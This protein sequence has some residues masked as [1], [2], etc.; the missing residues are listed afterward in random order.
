MENLERFCWGTPYMG[1]LVNTVMFSGVLKQNNHTKYRAGYPF[2]W[3]W[4]S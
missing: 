2:N 3:R 1:D 4:V